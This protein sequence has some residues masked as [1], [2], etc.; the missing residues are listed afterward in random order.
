VSATGAGRFAPAAATAARGGAAERGASDALPPQTRTREAADLSGL[1]EWS[2][3]PKSPVWWGTL[4]FVAIEGAGFVLAIG[5]HLYL[6]QQNTEWPLS[7]AP[8]DLWPGTL[9]LVILLASLLPNWWVDRAAKRQDLRRVRIGLVAMT[10]L[11]LAPLVVRGFEFADLDVRWDQNAYGSMV[12]LLLGLHTLHLGTDWGDTAVLAALMF[13]RHAH[14]KRF[15]DVSDNAFYWYF[16]VGAW[17]PIWFLL[18]VLPR[19]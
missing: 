13:T 8:P 7:A 14:G 6:W 18:Y 3:G 10:L 19:L 2:F 9:N 4:G 12:W 16:V 1:P 15:S 11:S 5:A 17:V